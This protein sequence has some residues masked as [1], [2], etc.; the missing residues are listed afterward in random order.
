MRLEEARQQQAPRGSDARGAPPRGASPWRGNRASAFSAVRLAILRLTHGRALLAAVAL[1]MLV[2]VTLICTVPLFNSLI[3]DTQLQQDINTKDPAMQNVQPV[4]TLAQ[5]SQAG[6]K[7]VE[8]L[9]PKLGQQYLSSFTS[10]T[11]TYFTVSDS[12]VLHSADGQTFD[13]VRGPQARLHSF[14]YAQI[15]PHMDIIAGAIPQSVAS[16]DT[17]QV[18]ITKEMATDLSLKIGSQVQLWQFG[19]HDNQII[20]NVVGIWQPKS[21][22][23]PFWNDYQFSAGGSISAPKVYPILITKDDFF[24]ALS[25]FSGMGS[26]QVWI[27]R[28]N[29]GAINAG[30][31][32]A[33]RN[34]LSDFRSRMSGDVQPISGVAG[35]GVV[36]QLDKIIAGL[37]S[38]ESLL[39]LPLYVVVAQVVGLAL[40]FVVAMAGL[41]IEGQSQEIAT[42][43]S[44]GASGTQLLG[45]FITQGVI[46]GL[47]SAVAGA[48]LAAALAIALVRAFV[49]SSALT[50]LPVGPTYLAQL[51]SPKS[52]IGPAL[53]GALLGVG[54]ITFSAFQTA[55]MDVLAFRREQGRQSRPPFWARYYLD[56]IFAGLC[57]VGYL[58][59][60]Q[61]GD[62]SI[63]A[64]LPGGSSSPL[65]LV[66]P[67]LLLLAGALVTLRLAPMAAAIGQRI[68]ARGRGFSAMIAFAQVE[69][70]PAK[71][72]RMTLLLTLAVGLGI[73]AISYNASLGQNVRDSATYSVGASLRI[74]QRFAEPP[75]FAQQVQQKYASQPGVRA[76]TPV[77]RTVASTTADQGSQGLGMLVVDPTSFAQVVNPISWRSDYASEPLP[78]LMSDLH[79]HATPDAGVSAPIWALVSQNFA[80]QNKVKVGDRFALTLNENIFGSTNFIVGSIVSGF[81][82]LYPNKYPDGFVIV[83]STSFSRAVE[84]GNANA[85]V[86]VGPNEFWAATDGSA[87]A[88]KTLNNFIANHPELD[89]EKML[90]LRDT[91][92]AAEANPVSSGMRGL[93]LI[94]AIMAALLAVLG[95]I[96][97]S[98]LAARQRATQFAVLR[99][100][101][102]GNRDLTQI[103]LS[104]QSVV[105]VF[106]LVGG[107]ALGALLVTATLPFLQFSD[108]PVDPTLLGTPP[109]VLVTDPTALAVFYASLLL[110]F[111]IALLIAARFA[112]TV[113][114]GRALRLG[115]D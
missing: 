89:G 41:L 101:G 108:Q 7:Q 98:A 104:E 84:A 80:Q 54:A 96:I 20:G 33:T 73:F 77:Y 35:V 65:L 56:L 90:S 6:R 109:Y 34:Q 105:Y 39:A 3:L 36:S 112:A 111:I 4:V 32:E 38:Q 21:V 40:L 97:Q 17:L 51:A 14:D 103:L 66:S 99:T 86:V 46:L 50:S 72:M 85:G 91:L 30:N 47:L 48:F 16:G 81:P 5:T 13:P 76:I 82:T 93:L 61:F 88:D 71:Y 62:I 113:G 43:K 79:T 74:N 10:G 55:Q 78:Q 45:V 15:A 31:M 18:I 69:R 12:M 106:G 95:A 23:D 59:L 75:Q 19:I 115:E 60:G 100:L 70:T 25:D 83:D 28:T 58:E 1:G 114:L 11:P 8:E 87:V 52:V 53:I 24:R 9:I 102:V 49:P 94:G 67:A 110:A 22:N 27:Y 107:S 37:D 68:A 26:Q 92:A 2:A 57:L 64:Q 29:S 63:R 44:R 42:L